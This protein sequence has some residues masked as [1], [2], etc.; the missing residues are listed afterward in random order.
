MSGPGRSRSAASFLWIFGILTLL[1]V[2]SVLGPCV[3][4]RLGREESSAPDVSTL[5]AR[6]VP[7]PL[8][9]PRPANRLI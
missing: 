7:E 3:V 8:Q 2:L 9:P 5:E 6:P 4:D 1:T